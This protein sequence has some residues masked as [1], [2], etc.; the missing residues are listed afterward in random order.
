VNVRLGGLLGLPEGVPHPMDDLAP[1]RYLLV[2]LAVLAGVCVARGR[3]RAAVALAALQAAFALGFWLLALPV[4][5]GVPHDPRSSLRAADVRVAAGDPAADGAL[6]GRPNEHR[7]AVAASTRLGVPL[8][9]AG[10]SLLAPLALVAA[11]VAL[12]LLGPPYGWLAAILWLAACVVDADVVGSRVGVVHG[13]LDRPLAAAALLVGAPVLAWAATRE[14]GRAAP[15]TAVAIV[16]LAT[17]GAARAEGAVPRLALLELPG[18]ALLNAAAATVAGLAGLAWKPRSGVAALVA[19]SAAALVLNA[20]TG[21]ADPSLAVAFLRLGLALAAAPLVLALLEQAAG[22][23]SGLAT[24][25]LVA[26]L[27]GGSALTWWHPDLDATL[28]DS[29]AEPR[30]A[31]REAVA[32]A[33][34]HA[35][36]EG[37]IVASADAAP[38]VASLA[39]RRILRAPGLV[40][41]DDDQG[42]AE[43]ERAVLRG[44]AR[45]QDL[46]RLRI[47]YVLAT[48]GGFSPVWPQAVPDL[49]A[50]GY[51][52]VFQG[53]AGVRVYELPPPN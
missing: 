46:R 7:A 48:P 15:A 13:L 16:A 34:E 31:L 52:L 27:L 44:R 38:L 51:A 20:A 41:T 21:L 28:S 9:V 11:A 33:R 14:K 29:L 32:W 24:G 47:R 18:F 50:H 26:G 10:P 42:R 53:P 45:P 39:G 6:A 25:V 37:T 49:R 35:A 17:L 3:P 2:G 5:Y 43:L 1:W 36:A 40:R 8:V 19:S 30:P 4:P 12:A 23:R 22:A